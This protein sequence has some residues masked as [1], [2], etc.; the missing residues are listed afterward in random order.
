LALPLLSVASILFALKFTHFKFHSKTLRF[1]ST[2]RGG[3]SYVSCPPSFS[4]DANRLLVGCGTSVAIFSTAT[5]LQVSSLEGHTST[6]TSVVV[7]PGSNIL[8][9]CWTSS[10]DG[11][12][13]H[14]DFSLLECIKKIDLNLP[15]FSM[16]LTLSFSIQLAYSLL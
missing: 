7:V 11:T 4:N 16:V 9:Y 6:V 14:W 5:A 15:I 12:I 3:Q 8:N 2:M 13:R 1:V 10:L